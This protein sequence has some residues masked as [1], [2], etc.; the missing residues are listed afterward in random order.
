MAPSNVTTKICVDS[1][2]AQIPHILPHLGTSSDAGANHWKRY[3][4]S[5]RTGA[6][7]LRRF[8]ATRLPLLADVT[9]Q[10]NGDLDVHFL[11]MWEWNQSLYG[12]DEEHFDSDHY[13]NRDILA[14]QQAHVSPSM[15]AFAVGVDPHMGTY[16]NLCPL[17]YFRREGHQ[18]DSHLGAIVELMRLPFRMGEEMEAVFSI[19]Q[20]GPLSGESVIQAM[21]RAGFAVDNDFIRFVNE[22]AE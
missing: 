17:E 9:E 10:L 6:A 22:H 19:E 12:V 2:C 11:P 4:K 18:W 1:I 14:L 20:P 7:I 21:A 8:H 3:H 5:G 16:I 15:F 13:L